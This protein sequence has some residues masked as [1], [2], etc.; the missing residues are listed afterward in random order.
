MNDVQIFNK[1]LL[2]VWVLLLNGLDDS[3]SDSL[4][5]VSDS[6]STKRRVLREDLNT[7][8]LLGDQFDHGSISGFNEFGFLFNNFTGSSV[9][10]GENL[11]EFTGDMGC[12]AIEDGGVTVTDLSG[13]IDDDDLS[14]ETCSFSC[15]VILGIRADVS[16]L[17][18]FD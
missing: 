7:H 8:G 11:G 13:V 14:G 18:F 4:L 9:I 16:S 12:V 10:L 17:Q 2:L 6:E 1:S 3:D 15:G 5:H